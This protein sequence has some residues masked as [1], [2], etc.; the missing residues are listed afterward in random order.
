MLLAHGAW[1]GLPRLD[2]STRTIQIVDQNV[3]AGKAPVVAGDIVEVIATLPV[4]T[5]GSSSGPGGWV[6]FYVPKGTQVVGA[7]VL[8]PNQSVVNNT[9]LLAISVRDATNAVN[10]DTAQRGWGDGQD[11]FITTTN[12]WA[13]A[14]P[15]PGCAQAGY[16]MANCNAGS[17]FLYGDTGIFYSTRADTALYT[18]DGTDVAKFTNGYIV[19]PSSATPWGS[20]GGS[21]SE[22]VHNKWDAVQSNAF[23]SSGP[24]AAN[25]FST[26]ENTRITGGRGQTPF[27]TG[28]PVAGPDAYY[29]LDRY[30]TV[31]PWNR[32]SYPGS[33]IATNNGGAAGPANGI[34]SVYP[35]T[36]SSALPVVSVCTR[37]SAGFLL[38][39]ANPLPLGTNNVRFAIGGIYAGEFK[40][41]MLRLRVIDPTQIS[42]FNVAGSGGDAS[43]LDSHRDNMWRYWIGAPAN[44][45]VSGQTYRLSLDKEIVAVN[46]VAYAPGMVVPP[47]AT[48]RYRI[49]Y[50]N[51]G[52]FIQTNVVLSD[53]LPTQTTSTSNFTV[54]RGPNILPATNPTGGTFSFPTIASL[55]AL[56]GGAIEFDVK[57]TAA[58]GAVINN[59][60]RV[61]S[62]Q[63]PTA[64]TD[65]V[66]LTV[67]SAQGTVAV[68]KSMQVY[69]PEGRGLLAVP[70]NDV[71]YTI[72]VTN[73]GSQVDPSALVITD[74]LPSSLI[75]YRGAFDGTT[76]EPVKFLEG[77]PPSG[78]TC[79]S[80]SH[81]TYSTNGGSSYSYIAPG[82]YD[83]AITHV[84]VKPSGP[85]PTGS[86]F[87]IAFRAKIK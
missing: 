21:G 67:S 38:S 16:T 83:P 15:P 49:T 81:I 75:F 68:S 23:G 25:G 48:L 55:P 13:P 42:G 47:N 86:K 60:G 8:D 72:Q 35:S 17:G 69:D 79:C 41:V 78:L 7:S 19:N 74:P 40:R 84:R 62:S 39:E 63:L 31:G 2:L 76:S 1:L 66:S 32:I 14:V 26:L 52:P 71:I 51:T 22:R 54:I 45:A 9:N 11:T 82:T 44:I 12:G 6:T 43:Y 3:L 30:G 10:G 33:C 85:M 50:A 28:S 36:P 4:I 77:S 18:G 34:N 58:S 65:L 56:T 46:G 37:T 59:T 64:L 87:S 20:I 24:S 57:V 5:S 61:L 80:S 29:T 73:P 70:G 27:M 53:I